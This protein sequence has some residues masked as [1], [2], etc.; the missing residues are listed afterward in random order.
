MKK[1]SRL[2][3]TVLVGLLAFGLVAC[4]QDLDS[5][6][7]QRYDITRTNNA[8]E[9]RDVDYVIVYR[10]VR[11]VPN[12]VISCLDGVAFASTTSGES[13]S[14]GRDIERVAEF[15]HECDG[16]SYSGDPRSSDED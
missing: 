7:G 1:R 8:D 12:I 10:N 4:D 16:K 3:T 2:L 14:S 13:G 6:G 5:R 11:R 9:Y 15:D